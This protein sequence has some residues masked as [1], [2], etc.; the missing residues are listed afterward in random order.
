MSTLERE[1][2]LDYFDLDR[3]EVVYPHMR[4]EATPDIV[5]HLSR[6][7]DE[8]KIK[9]S[10]ISPSELEK[11]I[12]REINY[13]RSL[14][15]TLEWK[16]YEHE[17]PGNLLDVLKRTG[18]SISSRCAV[19]VVDLEDRPEQLLKVSKHDIRRITDPQ[20]LHK[21]RSVSEAVWNQPFDKLTKFMEFF[22]SSHP[23]YMSVYIAHKN[24]QPV[25][26]ARC[27]F[28][29][30]SQFSYLLGG[31]THPDYRNQGF[32]SALVGV[33]AQEAIDREVRFLCVEAMPTSQP[34][35]EKIGFR[36]ISYMVN[37]EIDLRGEMSA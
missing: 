14:N 25:S 16:V 21:F 26:C 28:H 36:V 29:P 17:P 15:R 24:N 12:E 20:H 32:Y 27:T 34:I 9:F 18:F 30:E 7:E 35:L 33:R 1:E 37:C 23:D 13:E 4:R 19:M 8:A 22:L 3:R 11:R 10:C 2:V 6:M 5:R 31:S